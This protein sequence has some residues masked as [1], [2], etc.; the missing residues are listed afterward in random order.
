MARSEAEQLSICGMTRPSG[1]KEG[2]GVQRV[3]T[4]VITKTESSDHSPEYSRPSCAWLG[5]GLGLGLGL[6]LALR[7]G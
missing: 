3:S 6:A 4:S 2:P 5:L 7:L 1:K